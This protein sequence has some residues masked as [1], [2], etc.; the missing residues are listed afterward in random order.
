MGKNK[1]QNLH[2]QKPTTS[3]RIKEN[4]RRVTTI[5]NKPEKYKMSFSYIC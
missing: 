3:K 2:M 5:K 1:W 4:K